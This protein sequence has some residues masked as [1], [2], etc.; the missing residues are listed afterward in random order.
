MAQVVV[1]VAMVKIKEA[2][3]PPAAT[4]ETG[5]L[6]AQTGSEKETTEQ[7]SMI[8]EELAILRQVKREE[9]RWYDQE[10]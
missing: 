8:E 3:V 1:D 4:R 2:P 6:K 7:K 5:E 9:G 10:R